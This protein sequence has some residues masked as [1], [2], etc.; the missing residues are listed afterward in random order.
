V[1]IV[2]PFGTPCSGKSFIWDAWK[3]QIEATDGWTCDE[4]SSD[5]IRAQQMKKL[6]DA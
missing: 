2:I 1:L 3:K 6:M 4:V 5:G